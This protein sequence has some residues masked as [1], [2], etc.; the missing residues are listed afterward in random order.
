MKTC[1]QVMPEEGELR[2]FI[3]GEFQ[4]QSEIL[5]GLAA[6]VRFLQASVHVGIYADGTNGFQVHPKPEGS[7]PMEKVLDEEQEEHHPSIL[8]ERKSAHSLRNSQRSSQHGFAKIDMSSF[9]RQQ[10]PKAK[11]SMNSHSEERGSSGSLRSS[12]WIITQLRKIVSSNAFTYSILVLIM[13]NLVLLGVEVDIAAAMPYHETP[14]W[15]YEINLAVVVIFT[16]E[17]VAKIALFGYR[18]FFCGRDSWWNAFDFVVVALSVFELVVE[19]F[20][21]TINQEMNSSNLRVMRFVRVART[22]RGVR[23]IRLLKYIGSL[24]TIVF[25]IISTIGSLFWTLM[26]LLMV[27]YCFSVIITQSVSDYCRSE[28]HFNGVSCPPELLMHWSGIAESM[29]TLFLSISGGLSWGEA[30]QPLRPV[31]PTPFI[32][33]NVYIVI[34]IFAILNV[35]T[36]VFCNTAIESAGA[37]REIAIM[38]QMKKQESQMQTL[39][40]IFEEI[41]LDCSSEINLQELKNALKSQK[42]RTFMNSIGINTEDVWT[43]FMTVDTDGSGEISLDEFVH[44]CMQLQGPA[45]GLQVARMSYENTVMRGEIKKIREEVVHFQ[46]EFIQMQRAS[47]ASMSPRP[48][49]SPFGPSGSSQFSPTGSTGQPSPTA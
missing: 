28:L 39:K 49:F 24:R 25:S 22:L 26:L 47:G 5:L 14:K 11:S 37:D 43:L 30:L 41:D 48:V 27:F 17:V 44:G 6:D 19:L 21:A 10:Q 23:V 15:F 42:L 40:D 36:G 38:K 45:K 29:L 31:G 4:K 8:P 35:V 16:F 9:H 13:V 33:V 32:A 7:R 1:L 34:T 3:Q 2:N 12:P 18:D 46:Q 20:V